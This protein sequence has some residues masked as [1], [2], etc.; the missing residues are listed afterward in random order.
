MYGQRCDYT[1]QSIHLIVSH[2]ASLS[3]HDR[4]IEYQRTCTCIRQTDLCYSV[5]ISVV[6]LFTG[7]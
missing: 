2:T 6:A 1:R 5:C 7:L 3:D 4:S